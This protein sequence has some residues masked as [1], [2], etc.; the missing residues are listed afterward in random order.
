MTAEAAAPATPARATAPPAAPGRF[1]CIAASLG[2]LKA[3]GT[4]LG[5]LPPD[6]PAPILLVQHLDPTHRSLLAE[7]LGRKTKL[8]VAEGRD[9]ERVR[10]GPVYVAPP[11]R[12]MRLAGDGR[13]HMASDAR[14]RFSRPSAD[15]MFESAAAAFDGR[16]I[17]VVLTGM[18]SDG[19]AGVVRAKQAGS[20]IIVQDPATAEGGGM[21]AAA[22]RTG[23][24]DYVLPLEAIAG[25]LLELVRA[26]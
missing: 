7:L 19:A 20:V 22:L 8:A 26:A 9:G 25:R 24:A 14:R 18:G 17:L 6:F 3:L 4:V 21:P 15:V 16:C 12:H 2:G 5:G 10:P 13:L 1:V 23:C 11:D